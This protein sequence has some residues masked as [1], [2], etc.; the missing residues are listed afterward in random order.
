MATSYISDSQKEY[1]NSIFDDVFETFQR[2]ITVIMNPEMTVLTTSPSY[3]AFYG[4][5]D[6]RAVNEPTYTT[7][8]YTFK[9]KIRYL[10]N[11]K[12]MYPGSTNQTRML[13][14]AGTVKIKV[15]A[16]AWPYL[17]EARKV[18]FDGRRY[19]FASDYKPNGMFGPRYYSFLLTPINE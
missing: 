16:A 2:S 14:P 15:D 9:A 3:N 12:P 13:Y 19:Q 11:D 10:S 4:T 5:D 8:S 7:K 18:E 6:S 17:K 1:I